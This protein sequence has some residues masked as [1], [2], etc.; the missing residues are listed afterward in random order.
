MTNI[1]LLCAWVLSMALSASATPMVRNGIFPSFLKARSPISTSAFAAADDWPTNVV[2][3]GGSQSYGLWVPPDG[4]WYDFENIQCLGTPAYAIGDCNDIT[5]DQIGVVPGNGPCTFTTSAGS[6]IVV[7][8]KA[9]DGFTTVGPPQRI[10][11][12]VCGS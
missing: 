2:F 9:G 11:G 7:A 1:V 12:A 3:T 4:T 6:N 8:G 10:L 5:I